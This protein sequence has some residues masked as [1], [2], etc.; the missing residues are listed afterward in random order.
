MTLDYTVRGQVKI[1]MFDYVDNI[2]N[3]FDK[4]EPKGGGTNTSTSPD[5]LLNVDESCAKLAQNKAVEF[6][7]LVAKTV[8]ATKPARLDTCTAIAF[9]ATRVQEPK[10]DD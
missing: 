10:K 7:N 3:A 1:T 4:A 6:H 5:S 2:L 8:Y 9:L